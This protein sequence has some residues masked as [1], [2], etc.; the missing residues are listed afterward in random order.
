MEAKRMC[1]RFTLRAPAAAVR[2]FFPLFDV[3][4]D[5]EARYNVAPTQAV[6][7]VRAGE[8]GKQEWVR[9]RWGL[10]PA[11]ADDPSIGNRLINARS[12]TAA[13]KASFR[14]A[15]RGRRCLVLAD[16][17]YEW[18]KLPGGKQPFYFRLRDGR[19][20]AF[21]G[22][23]E[24]WEK[25]AKPLETCTLLTTDANELVRPVHDRMPVILPPAAFGPWLDAATAP[26]DLQALLAPY[27]AEGMTG[28]PVSARVNNPRNEGP[29]C[30]APQ[31]GKR[32]GRL[33]GACRRA[34]SGPG[35]AGGTQAGGIGSRARPPPAGQSS[36]EDRQRAVSAAD[37]RR[38]SSACLM[39]AGVISI[40]LRARRSKGSSGVAWAGCMTCPLERPGETGAPLLCAKR[41]PEGDQ[42]PRAGGGAAFPRQKKT[43]T[44]VRFAPVISMEEIE[45]GA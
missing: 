40:N 36:R 19:P 24:R 29:L 43:G 14:S 1:G 15:F 39:R 18:Q 3:P 35:A 6:L 34:L 23:W 28:H 37:S 21:A 38:A 20:F 25:G 26:P 45:G 27:P 12:E 11:W 22:L 41:M 31:G 13:S 8:G 10:V 32:P 4:E 16:G 30:V 9:L 5:L 7:T 17:F 44:R 2:D 33:R 42:W